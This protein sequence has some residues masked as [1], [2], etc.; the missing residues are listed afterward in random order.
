MI[1]CDKKNIFYYLLVK[2]LYKNQIISSQSKIITNK[3]LICL[4]F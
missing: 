1:L 4:S 2:Y 3:T